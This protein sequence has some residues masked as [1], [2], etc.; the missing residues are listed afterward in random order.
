MTSSI[1]CVLDLL[2][3]LLLLSLRFRRFLLLF[4]GLGGLVVSFAAAVGH[5]LLLVCEGFPKS[6]ISRFGKFYAQR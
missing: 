6:G 4:L 5:E 1:C 2:A 3:R